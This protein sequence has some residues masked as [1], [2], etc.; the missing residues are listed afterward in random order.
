MSSFFTFWK[1][2]PILI[3]LVIPAAP[4]LPPKLPSL[5]TPDV[6]PNWRLVNQ[7]AEFDAENL[8]HEQN[9]IFAKIEYLMNGSFK[10]VFTNCQ[11]FIINCKDLLFKFKFRNLKDY[12][13]AAK[14]YIIEMVEW[15]SNSEISYFK[16]NY[17]WF[18]QDYLL[19]ESRETLY[20]I[21]GILI[22]TQNKFTYSFVA[23]FVLSYVL[24]KTITKIHHK[25]W[26]LKQYR[27]MAKRTK[28]YYEEKEKEK[29]KNKN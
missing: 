20:T 28:L 11:K 6:H 25:L 5:P 16:A 29:N 17:A 27:D 3:P 14:D 1:P 19:C 23:A 2:V 26:V 10:Y 8:Y 15:S 21:S 24:C 9:M 7:L 13:I 4:Q 12:F 18:D 22:E